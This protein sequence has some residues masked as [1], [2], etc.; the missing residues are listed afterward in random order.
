MTKNK[1]PQNNWFSGEERAQKNI[2]FTKSIIDA[3]ATCG[4]QFG[5]YRDGG[6]QYIFAFVWEGDENILCFK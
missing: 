4:E 5:L 2:N 1:V 6:S 3:V